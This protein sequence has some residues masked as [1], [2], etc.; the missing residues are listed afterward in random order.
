SIETGKRADLAV[1]SHD[2]TSVD[3]DFIRE[4][5]VEQ[6]YVDGELLHNR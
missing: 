4:I 3:P 2:P 5:S 6:T 1:L